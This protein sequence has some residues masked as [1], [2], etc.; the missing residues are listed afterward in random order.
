MGPDKGV[1]SP[2]F[3]VIHI[4]KIYFQKKRLDAAERCILT[5]VLL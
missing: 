5:E 4:Q 3:G 2:E 1:H